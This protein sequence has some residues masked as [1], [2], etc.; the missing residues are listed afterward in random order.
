MSAIST[1]GPVS[2][3]DQAPDFTL[4]RDGGEDVTLRQFRGRPVIVYFY[5]RDDTPGCTRQAIAFTE[6]GDRLAAHNTAVIGIS[7][8]SVAS[9]EKFRDKHQLNV[10]LASDTQGTVLERYGVWVEKKNYGRTYMGIERSSFLIG[11]DGR[12]AKVW[13]KVR[14]PG[15]V[16]KVLDA[17][18]E[19]MAF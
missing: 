14:V 19:M 3:G 15:H 11:A 6:A 2:E 7:K 10:I 18:D 4:P 13:R 9:H 16:D 17:L 1:A 5:P 8:D 12:I